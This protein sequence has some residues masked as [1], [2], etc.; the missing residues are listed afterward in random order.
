LYCWR[1]LGCMPSIS[2]FFASRGD[3][4]VHPTQPLAPLCTH[5][6]SFNKVPFQWSALLASCLA[7]LPFSPPLDRLRIHATLLSQRAYASSGNLAIILFSRSPYMQSIRITILPRSCSTY[8]H[9]TSYRVPT[10]LCLALP[11][12]HYCKCPLDYVAATLHTSWIVVVTC[13]V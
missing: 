1:L 9:A 3:K 6:S 12:L 7:Y 5:L 2:L 8:T 13:P 11:W 10:P 4:C